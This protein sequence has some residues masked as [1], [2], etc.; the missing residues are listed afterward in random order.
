MILKIRSP[1]A[2][3][4]PESSLSQTDE[5]KNRLNDDGEL[6]NEG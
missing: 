5:T 1:S 6:S 2:F 3:A 4:E